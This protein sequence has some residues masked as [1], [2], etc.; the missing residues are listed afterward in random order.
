MESRPP[1]WFGVIP[2]GE[3][4]TAWWKLSFFFVVQAT[5]KSRCFKLTSTK[6]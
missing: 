5:S 1:R 6:N 4:A 2:V 3:I